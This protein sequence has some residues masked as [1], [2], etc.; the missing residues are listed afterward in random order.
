MGAV[1]YPMELAAAAGAAI[2][3]ILSFGS[4]KTSIAL[5][6]P[7][8]GTVKMPGATGTTVMIW[9]GEGTPFTVTTTV[10]V[11]EVWPAGSTSNGS[12]ALIIGY[13]PPG[14]TRTNGPMIPLN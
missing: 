13:A 11:P 5:P 2:F 12:C 8:G 3:I 6:R 9:G 14:A 4:V 1:G 10:A 7:F